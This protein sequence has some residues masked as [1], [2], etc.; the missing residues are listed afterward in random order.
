MKKSY[1][2]WNK[3]EVDDTV[4][5]DHLYELSK[6]K[7]NLHNQ[8]RELSTSNT[9]LRTNKKTSNKS[10]SNN[11]KSRTTHKKNSGFHKKKSNFKPQQP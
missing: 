10:Y 3:D 8:D 5:F 7:I 2:S 1:L 6:G 11:Q 4:I 9:L